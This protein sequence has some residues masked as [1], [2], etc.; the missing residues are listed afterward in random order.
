MGLVFCWHRCNRPRIYRVAELGERECALLRRG[1]DRLGMDY[2]DG[3]A[4]DERVLTIARNDTLIPD[5]KGEWNRRVNG[6]VALV[7]FRMELLP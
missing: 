5:A 4:A 1:S 6:D 2:C 7:L 3:G